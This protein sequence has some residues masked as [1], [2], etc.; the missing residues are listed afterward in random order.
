[1]VRKP[2]RFAK[3]VEGRSRR[4]TRL[5]R[6]LHEVRL[7][8]QRLGADRDVAVAPQVAQ[9]LAI[10]DALGPRPVA[11][12]HREDRIVVGTGAMPRQDTV[13][14]GDH[15]AVDP[16]TIRPRRGKSDRLEPLRIGCALTERIAR[17]AI[18]VPVNL[19]ALSA[20]FGP[21]SSTQDH[22]LDVDSQR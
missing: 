6:R 20:I 5:L 15:H 17:L 19:H 22:L 8:A 14:G 16:R 18:E 4:I 1:M 10:G 11:A 12:E 21:W 2:V 7:I 13:R 3:R 9:E